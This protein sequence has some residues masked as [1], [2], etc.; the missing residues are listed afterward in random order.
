MGNNDIKLYGYL[1]HETLRIR[2]GAVG[3]SPCLT[4]QSVGYMM[5]MQ[6]WECLLISNVY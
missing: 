3:L 4:F 1:G 6:W 2:H 5:V